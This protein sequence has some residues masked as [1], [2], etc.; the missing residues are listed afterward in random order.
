MLLALCCNR[1]RDSLYLMGLE[2]QLFRNQ[3]FKVF[4][5]HK[6]MQEMAAH[7]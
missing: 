3:K 6:Q 5:T 7:L 2:K 1:K 4:M